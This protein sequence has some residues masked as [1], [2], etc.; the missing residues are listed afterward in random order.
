MI[1]KKYF[2]LKSFE[3]ED[4]IIYPIAKLNLLKFNNLFYHITYKVVAFKISENNQ[5]YYKNVS[6]SLENFENLKKK[7]K[8][9]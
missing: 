9:V 8:L 2:I 4:R 7:N 1:E 5:V 3:I 6:L